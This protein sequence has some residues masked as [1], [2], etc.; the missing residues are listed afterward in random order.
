VKIVLVAEES[1]GVRALQ[2]VAQSP[3]SLQ[4]VLT[5]GGS[6]GRGLSV[7]AAAQRLGVPTLPAALVKKPTFAAELQRE[8]VDVLLN[9]HALHL[10]CADV[11]ESLRV[12]GFNLH[13]GPLPEYAGL[14]LLAGQFSMAVKNTL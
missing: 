3:H 6:E 5:A 12:G 13:P 4:A 8:Q 10:V 9:V 2:L 7:Q 1:A 11:L 14:N